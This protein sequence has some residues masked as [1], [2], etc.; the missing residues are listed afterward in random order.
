MPLWKPINSKYERQSNDFEDMLNEGKAGAGKV[1]LKRM[2]DN[3]RGESMDKLTNED[4]KAGRKNL[5]AVFLDVAQAPDNL[6]KDVPGQKK[7][8]M[9]CDASGGASSSTSAPKKQNVDPSAV[10]SKKSIDASSKDESSTTNS[11]DIE[12][13]SCEQE[14]VESVIESDE[15]ED[16][17]ALIHALKD[18][19]KDKD[20][21]PD[22]ILL[23]LDELTKVKIE[24]SILQKTGVGKIVAQIRSRKAD[25]ESFASVRQTA[26]G[27]VKS[28]KEVA[29]KARSDIVAKSVAPGGPRLEQ[30][31]MRVEGAL[32]NDLLTEEGFAYSSQY[33]A[34][35]DWAAG[36]LAQ[37]QDLARGLLSGRLAPARLLDKLEQEQGYGSD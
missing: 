24:V 14:G 19:L 6:I 32:Y 3:G 7:V 4:R 25:D 17:T 37:D 15:P 9:I 11:K 28:W 13:T 20:A 18:I 21:D 2:R 10:D 23:I 33:L 5:T 35:I 12:S 36:V 26:A 30:L 8:E 27:L 29:A 16:P 22:D 31:V 1:M 34:R